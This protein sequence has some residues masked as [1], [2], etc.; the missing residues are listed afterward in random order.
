MAIPPLLRRSSHECRSGVQFIYL[1]DQYQQPQDH[2]ATEI[3]KPEVIIQ[4]MSVT[5]AF[6]TVILSRLQEVR[7]CGCSITM[8]KRCWLLSCRI[9]TSSNL[10]IISLGFWDFFTKS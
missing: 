5:L 9:I 2:D 4:P 1:F 3:D 8:L 7:R 6:L 10:K